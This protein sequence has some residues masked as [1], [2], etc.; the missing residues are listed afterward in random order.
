MDG[1]FEK[2]LGVAII[3]LG[4]VSKAHAK[5]LLELE[6]DVELIGVY[7][8]SANK[9][10]EFLSTHPFRDG[11][12]CYDS[13]EQIA[14]DSRVD[15]AIVLTPPNARVEIVD[16][17]AAA[18]KHLL[19]EKP[20]ERTLEA[21]QYIVKKCRGCKV[22]L[23]LVFQYRMRAGAMELK[24]LSDSGELG[25]LGAVE[26]QVPWW[27]N[28]SYYDE[29]GRGTYARD[30][31]GVLISQAIHTMELMTSIAGPVSSVQAIADTTVLHD[32][33]AE[34][35]VGA[36]L[37]FEN[38]AIGSLMASTVSFPGR[39]E[40]IYFHYENASLLFEG[41]TLTTYWRNGRIDQ[42]KGTLET[43][44]GADPMAFP[45]H[46]HRELIRDFAESVRENRDPIADGE[47][48]LHVHR[49]IDALIRSS[50]TGTAVSLVGG[51]PA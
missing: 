2:K 20:I 7:S 12:T 24:R 36:G 16:R 22:K 41:E 34:D 32:L 9:G 38:G 45:H 8:R 50:R 39:T 25:R 6:E 26:L 42:V 48:G 4:M 11:A 3:G 43:G 46:W 27:R 15:A 47:A 35:F 29:P 18:R 30:G 51:A 44:G 13:I 37:R 33:E 28:Q 40:H 10:R 49:L 14:A 19:I 1:D 21:A 5:A 31:G 23:G 17:L